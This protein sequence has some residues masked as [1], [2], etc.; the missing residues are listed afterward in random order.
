MIFVRVLLLVLA[1]VAPALAAETPGPTTRTTAELFSRYYPLTRAVLMADFPGDLEALERGFAEI[2][3][4]EV[5]PQLKL[6][7]A[8]L[9]LTALRKSY[10]P[11]LRYARTDLSALVVL[12]LAEFYRTVMRSEDPKVCGAFAADGAGTL[13]TLG[14][15]EV[16]A[17]ELDRQGAAYF[18]AVA[19]A[20]E[21]PDVVGPASSDDW[22]MV[23]GQIVADGHPPSY[24]A[25]IAA[26][27]ASDPDL[28]PALLALLQA[29]VEVKTDVAQRVRAEFIQGVT[30]Y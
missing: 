6:Q 11:K 1:L 10:A 21:N 26:A 2:D 20:L 14:Q 28:C 12:S 5:S 3:N 17:R 9:N 4:T 29:L 25:S 13:L 15:G 16:Y 27:K 19:S 23:M 18:T 22:K 8:F 24:I 30:G 7:R